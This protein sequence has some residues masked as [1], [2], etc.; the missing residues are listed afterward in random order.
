MSAGIT[1]NVKCWIR[2]VIEVVVVAFVLIF[3]V[4]M[5]T[6]SVTADERDPITGA[7][8]GNG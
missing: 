4:S 1:A 5:V 6:H 7:A 2:A 3:G 8:H